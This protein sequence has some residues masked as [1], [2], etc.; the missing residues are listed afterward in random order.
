MP[1]LWYA[2]GNLRDEY[3]I[4]V[5]VPDSLGRNANSFESHHSPVVVVADAK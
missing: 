3:S 2:H 5:L 4:L 1:K